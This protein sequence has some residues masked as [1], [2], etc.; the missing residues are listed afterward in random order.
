MNIEDSFRKTE[1]L[2][3][4]RILDRLD[5]TMANEL[6]DIWK[7]KLQALQSRSE[8]AI[9]DVT[10]RESEFLTRASSNE[11]R[12]F[13]MATET[14]EA[15]AHLAEQIAEAMDAYESFDHLEVIKQFSIEPEEREQLTKINSAMA[16][17]DPWRLLK[18]QKAK[19]KLMGSVCRRLAQAASDKALDLDVSSDETD[20]LLDA[21]EWL[22]IKADE[23]L[24]DKLADALIQAIGG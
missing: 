20:K 11:Q 5:I 19:T 15:L 7:G 14:R 1:A 21:K 22:L 8:S 4:S 3:R 9:E 16:S 23:S 18:G 24:T 2:C 10:G 6:L 12:G 13:A 17:L